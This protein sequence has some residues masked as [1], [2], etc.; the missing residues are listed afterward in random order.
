[1]YIEG[2]VYIN[3]ILKSVVSSSCPSICVLIKK[4]RE[5]NSSQIKKIKGKKW[6]TK[7]SLDIDKTWAFKDLCFLFLLLRMVWYGYFNAS[8][9]FESQRLCNKTSI[10]KS[11]KFFV[12]LNITRVLLLF[13]YTV[14]VLLEWFSINFC[15]SLLIISIMKTLVCHESVCPK[16]IPP[17][18]FFYTLFD[19]IR[20]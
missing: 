7:Y 3:T 17:P 18:F 1:M 12:W 5:V 11:L 6:R 20:L 9:R 8:L 4:E 14:C 16:K 13:K 2:A 19:I 15:F 10:I